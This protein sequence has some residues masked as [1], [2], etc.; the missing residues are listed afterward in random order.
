MG[1]IQ[2][3]PAEIAPEVESAAPAD[4]DATLEEKVE[5]MEEQ[6]ASIEDEVTSTEAEVALD[7]GPLDLAD[8]QS[9]RLGYAAEGLGLEDLIDVETNEE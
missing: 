5:A 7:E 8:L 4:E 9:K 2:M 3:N 1:M 6:I